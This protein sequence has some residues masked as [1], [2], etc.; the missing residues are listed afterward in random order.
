MFSCLLQIYRKHSL[1]TAI[2]RILINLT[3]LNLSLRLYSFDRSNLFKQQS[4]S[5]HQVGYFWDYLVRLRKQYGVDFWRYRHF[6]LWSAL[7]LGDN[8]LFGRTIVSTWPLKGVKKDWQDERYTT[9]VRFTFRFRVEMDYLNSSNKRVHY[10]FN[11]T[12]RTRPGSRFGSAEIIAK[13]AV[14]V[15]RSV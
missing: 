14:I 6:R 10:Y 9:H 12:F 5:I 15:Y 11:T 7:F 8:A 2:K 13:P 3:P 4:P 1:S